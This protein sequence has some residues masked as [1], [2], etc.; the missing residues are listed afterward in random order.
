MLKTKTDHGNNVARI[1]NWE[2]L[3][4]HPRT[5]NVSGKML[6]RFVDVY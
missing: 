4:K 3:G 6:P 2:T 1:G 5:M